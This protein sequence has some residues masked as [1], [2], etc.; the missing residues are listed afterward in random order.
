MKKLQK[1]TISLVLMVIAQTGHGG[2][3]LEE[4]FENI[5]KNVTPGGS[6]DSQRRGIF[7]AGNLQTRTKIMK[8]KLVQMEAPK[9]SAGCGGINMYGGSFSFI[10]KEQFIQ[11]IR[12]IGANASGYAFNLALKTMCESC[13]ATMNSLAKTVNGMNKHLKNS[14]DAG[15]RLVNK[16]L[17]LYDKTGVPKTPQIRFDSIIKSAKVDWVEP[18]SEKGSNAMK[19]IFGD[20]INERKTQLQD[21]TTAKI[22][23]ILSRDRI[24]NPNAKAY[25]QFK[26]E[27]STYFGVNEDDAVGLMLGVTGALI[28]TKGSTDLKAD[29]LTH[30]VSL[31]NLY[32][33]GKIKIQ[34]CGNLECSSLTEK[35]I[36]IK[37]FKVILDDLLKDMATGLTDK[38]HTIKETTKSFI[39][40]DGQILA[41][42][43]QILRLNGRMTRGDNKSKLEHSIQLLTASLARSMAEREM[44]LLIKTAKEMVNEHFT[45]EDQEAKTRALSQ[46]AVRE[47]E[48]KN[49]IESIKDEH[50]YRTDVLK[51]YAII[52]NLLRS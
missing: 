11:F 27:I 46:I 37:G 51:N 30:T 29:E 2:G 43:K 8:I 48:L 47:E 26:T 6:Y 1:F 44:K 12:S 25:E 31:K 41:I 32:D 22:D 10:N 4:E 49:E 28:V 21:E 33:G 16:G 18:I 45:V 36:T 42:L 14:C 34:N 13:N 35:E 17:E 9:L 20:D 5:Y 3:W 50:K 39:Q 24:A 52:K 15:K 7:T 40:S 19:A 23:E 38:T